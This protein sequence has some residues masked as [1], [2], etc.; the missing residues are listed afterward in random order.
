MCG[1]DDDSPGTC[2][3]VQWLRI[4]LP[5]QGV[6]VWPLVGEPRSHMCWGWQVL[7]QAYKVKLK[8]LKKCIWSL[9]VQQDGSYNKGRVQKQVKCAEFCEKESLRTTWFWSFLQLLFK[10]NPFFRIWWWVGQGSKPW[11]ETGTQTGTGGNDCVL[12]NRS[13]ELLLH[14]CVWISLLP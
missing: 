4:C 9:M 7:T 1:C 6:W 3:V 10:M 12:E 8:T 14:G 2:L 13:M 5:A 11:P